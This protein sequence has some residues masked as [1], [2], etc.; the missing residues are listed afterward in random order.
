MNKDEINTLIIK[1]IAKT[2]ASQ[3]TV[4]KRLIKAA[5]TDLKAV[6]LLDLDTRVDTLDNNLDATANG[7]E[8][9]ITILAKQ[10]AKILILE[11][12]IAV[13]KT[14]IKQQAQTYGT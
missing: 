12:E 2:N 1:Q 3:L 11:A 13:L 8:E 7:L 5:I 10:E 9:L 4:V 6:E 14:T